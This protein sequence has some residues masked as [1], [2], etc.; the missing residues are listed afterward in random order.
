LHISFPFDQPLCLVECARG[1]FPKTSSKLD[2]I[3]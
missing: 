2:L 1:P 3:A